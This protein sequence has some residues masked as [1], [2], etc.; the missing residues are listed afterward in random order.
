MP[1]PRKD[2]EQLLMPITSIFKPK[3]DLP[4]STIFVG[5]LFSTNQLLVDIYAARGV[6]PFSYDEALQDE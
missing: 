6:E 4:D 1:R 2:F 5:E 3:E